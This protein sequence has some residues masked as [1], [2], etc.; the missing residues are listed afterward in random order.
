LV[1]AVNVTKLFPISKGVFRKS[2]KFIHAVDGVSL[3]IAKRESFGLVGESGCGKT[4][5]G[6]LLVK[7]LKPSSGTI[8]YM[9]NDVSTIKKKELKSFRRKVHMIFQNPFESLSPRF[10]VYDLIN[11]PLIIHKIGAPSERRDSVIKAMED[12]GLT[13]IDYYLNK[14]PHELS[15]GERQRTSIARAIVV[16]PSFIVFDEPVTMLDTSIRASILKLILDLRVKYG[17]TYVFI[18]HDL[19]VARYMTEKL[20]IMYLGKIMEIGPT[21]DVIR[22]PIHPYSKALISAIPILDP[23]IE[24]VEPLIKEEITTPINPPLYCRFYKRCPYAKGICKEK[25]PNL[26]EVENGHYVSCFL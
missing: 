9:N 2:G 4:T 16:N 15:G 11:E 17:L 25:I 21:E 3:N 19:A 22:E 1:R 12:V 18:T 23:K 5:F 13:P 14:Y 24:R 10:T 7:L 6:K 8:Y 20:A 26:V